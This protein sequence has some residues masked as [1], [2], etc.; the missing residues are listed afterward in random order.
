MLPDNFHIDHAWESRYYHGM[1]YAFRKWFSGIPL[2]SEDIKL[3]R[4]ILML[5]P[6]VILAG[7]GITHLFQFPYKDPFMPRLIVSAYGIVVFASSFKVSL[8]KNQLKYFMYFFLLILYLWLLMLTWLNNFDAIFLLWVLMYVY[9]AFLVFRS[10]GLLVIFGLIV[11]IS[12]PVSYFLSPDPLVSETFLVYYLA[13]GIVASAVSVWMISTR[14]REISKQRMFLGEMRKARRRLNQAE[15]LAGIGYWELNTRTNELFI[16][17]GYRRILDITE[18]HRISRTEQIFNFI[19]EEERQTIKN[20]ALEGDWKKDLQFRIQSGAGDIKVINSVGASTD[21]ENRMFGYVIDI[22]SQ[23]KAVLEKEVLLR[24]IHHRVK[25]NLQIILSMLRLQRNLV[26]GSKEILDAEARIRTIAL[27]HEELYSS[28]DLTAINL[29]NYLKNLLRFLMEVY[30]SPETAVDIKIHLPEVSVDI[31]RAI[32][33]ALII[34]EL[35]SNA[36]KHAFPGRSR[37]IIELS[38]KTAETELSLT[39][40]D[41]GTGYYPEE[42]KDSGS[43][44]MNLISSLTSQLSG[45]LRTENTPGYT[46]TLKID[47]KDPDGSSGLPGSV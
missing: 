12:M 38:G 16:S 14:L 23:H 2:L 39:V 45:T 44:G 10:V 31:D 26:H 46:A 40:K 21:S 28:H 37:G 34:T 32:P 19:V 25:N 11:L 20:S 6:L 35:V 9:A 47:L 18:D 41:N 24:E 43:L 1:S 13:G 22:T 30:R 7:Y 8:V 36:M 42:G 15:R 17:P 29:S 4:F 3:Y 27:I 33:C 5:G